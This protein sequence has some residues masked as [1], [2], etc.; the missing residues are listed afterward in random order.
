[1]F[2]KSP[3]TKQFDMFNSP[4]SMM[5]VRESRYYDDPSNWHIKFYEEITSRIDE[6]IFKPLFTEGNENGKDGRPNASIRIIIAMCVIKEGYGYSDEN[7]FEICRFHVLYRRAL[8]MI[9]MDE[10]CPSLGA[11]YLLRKRICEYEEKTG[12]N[13]FEECF[14]NITRKQIKTYQI[15][16][17]SV[18]MDSKLISSNIAWYS[19]YEIIHKTFLQ[20]T[21]DYNRFRITD[22]MLRQ[23]YME[24][25]EE[26]AS[27]TVYRTEPEEMGNR[28]LRLGLVIDYILTHSRKSEHP[29]LERVFNEQYEKDK[30]GTVSVRDKKLVSPK[31]LQNPNDPDAQYRNKGGK[32]VKGYSAN[33]TETTDEKGKPGLITDIQVKGASA[34]DNGYLE[35]AIRNTEEVTGNKVD[36][37]YTD[38]AYQSEDNRKLAADGEHGFELVSSGIQGKPGRFELNLIDDNTLEVTDRE[39]SEVTTAIPTRNMEQ[40]KVNVKDKKGKSVWKYFGKEHIEKAEAR[41]KIDSVPIEKR[42]K[43]NN[44]EATIFQYCFHTRNNKTRYRGL[45]KHKLQAFARGLWINMRRLFIFDRKMQVQVA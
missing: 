7:L 24:F 27:K 8:G 11:Y 43:R 2:K 13:L 12:V 17:K 26:D 30:D 44:V 29:L 23:Q 5:C 41:R 33:L 21:Q 16:G 15:S 36:V 22:R 40:W 25:R 4:S 28:L 37:A 42:M 20:A 6:T 14:K 9:G 19:R 45:L 35:D 38:G 3:S 39:T 10:Q 1:M 31:S 34:P 32:V 18:R